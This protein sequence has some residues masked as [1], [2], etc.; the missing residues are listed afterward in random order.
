MSYNNVNHTNQ[1]L[2]GIFKNYSFTVATDADT[3]LQ[4]Y[5]KIYNNI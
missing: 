2:P 5:S 4:I 3:N 1:F